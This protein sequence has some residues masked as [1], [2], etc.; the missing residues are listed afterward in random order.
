MPS[1]F[2]GMNPYIEQDAIWHDFHLAFLPEIR[3]RLAAQVRP[4]YIVMLDEHI[5][6]HESPE[7]P[8]RLVGLA[9]VSVAARPRSGGMKSHAAIEVLEAPSEVRLR[10]QD[11]R[12]V[13]FLEV[14]DRRNRELIA[15]VELLSPSNKRGGSDRDQYVA[16][17]NRL[18]GTEAHF[19]EID[20]LR[21]GR[22]MPVEG[23]P[24]CAYSVLVSRAED[25]PRAG[26]WPIG[27]RKRLPIIPI[28]LRRPDENAR[29]DLQEALDH[30]Y[31][32]A[33]YEDFLYEGKPE[34]PLSV[35]DAA[36]ARRFVPAA[37]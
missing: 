8:R 7:R 26:F 13:P 14:R 27:L 6:V 32:A 19:V 11:T 5:Y 37:S 30:V 12:R 15:V 29:I 28:P 34:P 21:G 36:W 18:L 33:G 17:R 1:P 24:R 16:K 3:E 22:P 35:K 10:T 2:P 4:N 31:D 9:D 25:R 20:L 23:R